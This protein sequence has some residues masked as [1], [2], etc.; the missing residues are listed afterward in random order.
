MYKVV[1]VEDEKIVRQGIVHSTNWTAVDCMVV[2][3]AENGEAGIEVIEKL[4]PDLVITDIK[5]P[6]M[7]GIEMI[8]ELHK[9]EIKP[10][11]I[12]LTAYDDFSYARQ[13]IRL[14]VSDYVLKP[15]EDDQLENSVRDILKNAKKTENIKEP[16]LG[17]L[18]LMKGDKS[19]YLEA[20]LKY[21]DT[22]YSDPELSAQKVADELSISTGHL[23]HLFRKETDYTMS[24]YVLD[25]RMK[26]AKSLLKDYTHKVYEVAELVGYR[27][28]TYFSA[29]FKKYVGVTPSEYQDRYRE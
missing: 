17:N 27:D 11:V 21:I 23:S 13:G 18:T 14:G 6:K 16:E 20:A 28:I 9:R 25:C 15:F 3:E 10:Y 12:F 4:R 1:V 26:A 19:K 2:G 5:M 29:T 8:E 7:T 24:N 22:H